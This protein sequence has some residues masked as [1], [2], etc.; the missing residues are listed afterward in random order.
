MEEPRRRYPLVALALAGAAGVAVADVT[1]IPFAFWAGVSFIFLGLSIR[2]SRSVWTILAVVTAFGALHRANT[3]DPLA[4]ELREIVP[5]ETRRVAAVQG[6]V[7]SEPRGSSSKVV[8]SI[9]AERLSFGIGNSWVEVPDWDVTVRWPSGLPVRLGDRVEVLGSL[10][11]VTPARN[12]GVFDAKNW[13][14]RK[15]IEME[16]D[17]SHSRDV[18]VLQGGQPGLFASVLDAARQKIGSCLTIGIEDSPETINILRG[19]MLGDVGKHP[20]NGSRMC[21]LPV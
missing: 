13:L 11:R 1:P 4:R 21:V 6:R 10:S 8:I 2:A 18:A 19:I 17:A 7:I 14:F 16:I 5:A 12:P 3:Q 9:R 15:G 20:R